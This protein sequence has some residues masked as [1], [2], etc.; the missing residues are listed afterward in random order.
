MNRYIVTLRAI[1]GSRALSTEFAFDSHADAN[2]SDALA[3]AQARGYR[4]VTIVSI[5]AL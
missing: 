4:F 1:K 2:L 3:E 5:R